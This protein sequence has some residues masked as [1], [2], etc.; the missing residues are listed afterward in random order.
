MAKIKITLL[1]RLKS[2]FARDDH[3]FWFNHFSDKEK[4]LKRMDVWQLAKV[5]SESHINNIPGAEEDRIV[6]EHMLNVRLAK[7]QAMPAYV[8]IIFGL[9]GV[10]SGAYLNAAL[11]KPPAQCEYIRERNNKCRTQNQM[12]NLIPPIS[13]PPTGVHPRNIS[14]PKSKDTQ[15]KSN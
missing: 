6:A 5:I 2:L 13:P 14:M 15:N 4:A 8:A 3:D 7:I 1:D 11:Q 9:I 10:V 12:D